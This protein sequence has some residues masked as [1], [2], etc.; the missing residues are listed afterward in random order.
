MGIFAVSRILGKN[1]LVMALGLI[2]SS[3]KKFA[4][5]ST[6]TIKH[7]LSQGIST[8][9]N[10]ELVNGELKG[11]MGDINRLPVIDEYKNILSK[12]ALT[13]INAVYDGE[14]IVEFDVSNGVG[15]V[16]RLPYDYIMERAKI[17]EVTNAKIVERN[18][19]EYI[20]AIKGS[21][22]MIMK[23][24]IP[25]IN[26]IK[27]SESYYKEKVEA[28]YRAVRER[29]FERGFDRANLKIFKEEFNKVMQ[30][31]KEKYGVE[32]RIN[33]IRADKF[34]FTASVEGVITGKH[35]SAE[36]ILFERYC[37]K[38]G[39]SKS[40]FGK[41]FRYNGRTYKIYALNPRS[42]KFAVKGLDIET[43]E[44][45]RFTVDYVKQ[46]MVDTSW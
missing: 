46:N 16:S 25:D 30:Y 27:N 12:P 29:A 21:F 28:A 8:I 20:A 39:L 13:I 43:G 35:K 36:Q 37:E 32:I 34:R 31:M 11:T 24:V 26:S 10:V 6:D 44:L 19:K 45:Y 41:E 38:F 18:S 4:I 5:V 23:E 15:V 40:D 7:V 17:G 9:E 42:K 33:T 2:D 3:T 14:K 1:N 22:N